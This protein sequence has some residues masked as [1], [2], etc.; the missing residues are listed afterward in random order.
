M[1]TNLFEKI[2]FQ[3]VVAKFHSSIFLANQSRRSPVECWRNPVEIN[4]RTSDWRKKSTGSYQPRNKVDIFSGRVS[5]LKTTD[6][7]AVGVLPLR[8]D[9]AIKGRRANSRD[10]R[11]SRRERQRMR[12]EIKKRK[13]TKKTKK[14]RKRTR[15][16]LA[17]LSDHLVIISEAAARRGDR[18]DREGLKRGAR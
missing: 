16:L 9:Q 8:R 2:A 13:K 1:R 12:N 7:L 17:K 4:T 3:Q 11:K 6:S 5:S 10:E 15:Q 18:W 14:R